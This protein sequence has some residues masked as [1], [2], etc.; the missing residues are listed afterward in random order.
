MPFFCFPVGGDIA[1]VGFVVGF[2]FPFL[3]SFL[4]WGVGSFPR[5]ASG[6]FW[7]LPLPTLYCLCQG[8]CPGPSLS[9]VWV[10]PCCCWS[11]WR[12]P[13]GHRA[14]RF[15]GCVHV[16]ACGEGEGER[17]PGVSALTGVVGAAA[18]G[19]RGGEAESRCPCS[20]RNGVAGLA[21]AAFQLP[22]GWGCC[23][24][25][26]SLVRATCPA[27]R[28]SPG[29]WAQPLWPGVQDHRYCLPCSSGSSSSVWSR[30]PAFR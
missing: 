2:S 19:S 23:D 27:V 21:A 20:L 13:L 30:P 3:F 6:Y 7:E 22:V 24:Q 29:L 10:V 8:C 26:T 14:S 9:P 18:G 5:A 4:R 28:A 1:Q 25:A 12:R 11:C 17:K 16:P 15:L